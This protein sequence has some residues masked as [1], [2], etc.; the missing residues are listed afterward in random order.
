VTYEVRHADL[1]MVALHSA[2]IG[3]PAPGHEGVALRYDIV[4][5]QAVTRLEFIDQPA[6][7]VQGNGTSP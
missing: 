6:G 7:T 1:A 5:L 2:V 4:G 3:Y